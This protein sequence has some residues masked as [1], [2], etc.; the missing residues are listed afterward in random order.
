[1]HDRAQ[2]LDEAEQDMQKSLGRHLRLANT[3][4]DSITAHLRS[5]HPLSPLHRGFALLRS[6]HRILSNED[7]LADFD[8][9]EIVRRSEIAQAKIEKVIEK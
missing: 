6:D 9:V 8:R 4:L 2:Q 3:K 7:S 5:L 1:L